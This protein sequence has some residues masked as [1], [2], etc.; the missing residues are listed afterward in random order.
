[1]AGALHV[2]NMIRHQPNAG[3]TVQKPRACKTFNTFRTTQIQNRGHHRLVRVQRD[4][5]THLY[6][7][8]PQTSI[9]KCCNSPKY[10]THWKSK[11]NRRVFTNEEHCSQKGEV[12]DE[13]VLESHQTALLSWPCT[14]CCGIPSRIASFGVGAR[15]WLTTDRC[16]S[17]KVWSSRG[18]FSARKRENPKGTRTWGGRAGAR[19]TTEESTKTQNPILPF[20]VFTFFF[21]LATP[22]VLQTLCGFEPALCPGSR[23][24]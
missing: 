23:S 2:I 16:E 22:R 20:C 13:R 10:M 6:E 3:S 11:K 15:Q 12:R 7:E 19:G 17:L 24:H 14:A 18:T 9:L 8:H 1:M 21:G 5:G 4:T